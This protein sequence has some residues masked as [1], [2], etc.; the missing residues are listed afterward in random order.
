MGDEI[1][2]TIEQHFGDMTDPRVD[3]TKLHKPIDI[4]VMTSRPG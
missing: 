2:P 1:L 4:L 3:R